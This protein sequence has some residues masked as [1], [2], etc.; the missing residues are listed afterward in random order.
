MFYLCFFIIIKKC[1]IDSNLKEFIFAR[2]TIDVTTPTLNT[3]IIVTD[4]ITGTDIEHES[5]KKVIIR[6]NMGEHAR[7]S[8]IRT[9][10]VET[11]KPYKKRYYMKYKCQVVLTKL[12]F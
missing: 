7:T 11:G 4:R 10:Y 5:M 3:P 9:R 2:N 12:P 8:T 1:K 6:L